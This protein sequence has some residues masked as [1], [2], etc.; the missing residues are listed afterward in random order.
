MFKAT[1]TATVS[2]WYDTKSRGE[3]HLLAAS[4]AHNQFEGD[5]PAE[6]THTRIDLEQVGENAWK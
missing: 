2:F 5:E 1:V 4:D 3:A 6:W